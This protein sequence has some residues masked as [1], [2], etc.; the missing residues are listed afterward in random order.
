MKRYS[1]FSLIAHCLQF[2]WQGLK[3]FLI[4]LKILLLRLH[5]SLVAVKTFLWLDQGYWIISEDVV[6][7]KDVYIIDF[8]K[9][10]KYI[11]FF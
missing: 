3:L 11:N 4:A 6:D 1:V 10:F 9:I 7:P 5:Q 8:R 2:W